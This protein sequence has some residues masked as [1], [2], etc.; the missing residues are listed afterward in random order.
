MWL[1]F[2]CWFHSHASCFIH[3]DLNVKLGVSMRCYIVG[4]NFED[5]RV[6]VAVRCFSLWL[7]LHFT[8]TPARPSSWLYA[9]LFLC[10]DAFQEN[11]RTL[12]A[13]ERRKENFIRVIHQPWHFSRYTRIVSGCKLWWA[14][15]FMIL[16]CSVGV[17]F[18]IST[19]CSERICL[20]IKATSA[21]RKYNKRDIIKSQS[22]DH[23]TFYA[24]SRLRLAFLH[25]SE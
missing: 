24:S 7:K 14:Q 21:G 9:E 23:K 11:P 5:K 16:W 2:F 4:I 15:H 3:S 8:R 20:D 18:I 12:S 22:R 13:S 1:R 10:I 17:L 6:L 25:V 19:T